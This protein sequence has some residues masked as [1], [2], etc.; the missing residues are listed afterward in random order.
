LI[1]QQGEVNASTFGNFT[2]AGTIQN[3][4]VITITSNQC[5]GNDGWILKSGVVNASGNRYRNVTNAYLIAPAV[6]SLVVNLGLDDFK[7]TVTTSYY[8]PTDSTLVSGLISYSTATDS[9]ISKFWV[10]SP[11]VRVKSLS[12]KVTT[13]SV[14]ALS[15]SKLD[16]GD[17]I[18][19]SGVVNQ[20]FTLPDPDYCT[21]F[22]IG[23]LSAATRS[24][25]I[26]ASAGKNFIC[27]SGGTRVSA[28]TNAIGCALKFKALNQDTW[29]IV[30][31]VGTWTYT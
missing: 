10:A 29:Q 2:R 11:R 4:S 19:A 12:G 23:K 18:M 14:A 30:S 17:T 15:I 24:L 22:E 9:S 3:Q 20:V 27:G 6:N 26:K 1:T 21:E 5:E 7:D 13:S 31:E 8:L 16:T 25:T 28:V